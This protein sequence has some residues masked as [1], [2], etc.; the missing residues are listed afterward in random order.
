MPQLMATLPMLEKKLTVTKALS[1]LVES[2]RPV[3]WA[4]NATER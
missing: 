2:N 4:T 1:A 3:V